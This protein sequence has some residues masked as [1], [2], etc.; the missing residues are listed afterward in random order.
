MPTSLLWEF[1]LTSLNDL[2]KQT[3]SS[4]MSIREL[5]SQP[6]ISKD[7]FCLWLSLLLSSTQRR[8]WTLSS[9]SGSTN[10]K[11]M[12]D[13]VFQ[14]RVFICAHFYLIA[15][16]RMQKQIEILVAM[17]V[18]IEM[19]I[20]A[21]S[22]N[23]FV[24]NLSTFYQKKPSPKKGV[25][26]PNYGKTNKFW[27]LIIYI[28]IL[29]FRGGIERKQN[30]LLPFHLYRIRLSRHCWYSKGG[31]NRHLELSAQVCKAIH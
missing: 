6:R 17:N 4:M 19:F 30:L 5:T 18:P 2:T 28:M 10:A 29:Y 3:R 22:K 8:W 7:K 31:L 12:M 11:R 25:F 15:S 13:Y 26:V 1:S 20:T 21:V 24:L 9:V 27:L 23:Q 16:Y 14:S